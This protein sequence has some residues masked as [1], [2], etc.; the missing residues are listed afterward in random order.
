MAR[1]A[2]VTPASKSAGTWTRRTG[3]IPGRTGQPGRQVHRGTGTVLLSRGE[4][5]TSWT[6]RALAASRAARRLPAAE[7][8][9]V[10]H[11]GEIGNDHIRTVLLSSAC[12]ARSTPTT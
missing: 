11:V 10:Q 2:S 9:A 7:S 12:P 8:G 3:S 4:V 6:H 1:A 5:R